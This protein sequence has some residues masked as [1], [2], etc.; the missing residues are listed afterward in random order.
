MQ[1]IS[2]E[3]IDDPRLAPFRDLKTTNASRQE[4]LFVAEGT[5]LVERL[6]Y[7]SYSVKAVLASEQ[8]LRNFGSRIPDG[9]NVYVVSR[10][11]ATEL[12]GYKFH[13][14]VVA[15][16]ERKPE[17]ELSETLKKNPGLVL[18]GD[19]LID[20]ENVGALIRIA[21]GFGVSAVVLSRGTTDAFSRRVLRVSMGNGLFIPVVQNVDSVDTLGALKAADYRCCATV[22]DQSAM[23]LNNFSFAQRTVLVV[24]N[25]T[26]GVSPAALEA[27]DCRLTIPMLNGTD[28]LNV[29]VA[30]G[31]FCH[32]YQSQ[33][34]VQPDV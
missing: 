32:A 4:G 27:C 25:E 7:S 12:V 5:T 10:D 11:L 30:T 1:R 17:P 18:L 16:A 13:L 8:K 14:G 22:L 19:H 2:I 29:A 3:S 9:T 26:H 6:L 33:W 28:S 23:R 21:S 31:I 24:G 34:H 15:A 20:P